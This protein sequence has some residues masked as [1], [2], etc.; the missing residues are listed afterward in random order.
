[1]LAELQEKVPAA[2]EI[3]KEV[4]TNVQTLTTKVQGLETSVTALE[5]KRN[6]LLG[7]MAKLK[8]AQRI[9]EVAGLSLEDDSFEDKLTAMFAGRKKD[10]GTGNSDGDGEPG[11][12]TDF[13]AAL[14]P[15][16]KQ[17]EKLEKDLELERGEKEKAIRA[18]IGE[19]IDNAILQELGALK[20]TRPEHL[21]RLIRDQFTYDPESKSVVTNSEYDPKPIKEAIKAIAGDDEY[22]VYFPGKGT[23]GSGMQPTG[24]QSS[25]GGFQNPF[26]KKY[27]NST[28]ASA[29]I[30]REPEKARRLVAQARAAGDCDETLAGLLD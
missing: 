29:F 12:N 16:K 3:A 9:A 23:S 19:K 5:G 10:E 14:A 2:Y 28:T 4:S 22:S 17:L 20:C 6:Q 1:M 21:R 25:D 7:K 11:K 30:Q 15:L 13:Q 27:S 18:S 26:T 8:T 24:R